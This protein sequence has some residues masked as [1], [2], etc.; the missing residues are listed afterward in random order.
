VNIDLDAILHT[1]LDESE[2]GLCRMEEA[3]VAL[4]TEPENDETLQT[5]FRVA[6]TLKGNASSLGFPL[7]AGFAHGVEDTLHALRDR[8]IPVTGSVIT[9]LLRAVDALRHMVPEAVAG[10][11]EMSP[12]HEALLKLLGETGTMAV[13]EKAKAAAALV[14]PERRQR[15]WGRRKDDI[16]AWKDRGRT[17]RVDIE[18]LDRI[19]NLT[20]EIAIA[21]GRL[22]QMLE[23]RV[24]RAGEEVLEAHLEADRLYLD[25][26]ELV[27]KARMVPVGPIF[28]QYVRT[29]RD[30]AAATGKSVRLLTEGGDVEVDTRVIEHLRDPLTHMIRN[31]VD[32]GIEPPQGRQARGKD[33]CGHVSLR[34]CHEAGSIVIQV[35]DDGSGFDRERIVEQA[36]SEGLVAEPEKLTDAEIYRLVFEP[37]FSTAEAV[38]DLSGRGV[39]MDIVRRNVEAL[40]GS[41]AIDSRQGEGTT[42]TIRLPLTLAIIEGFGVGVGDETYVI[43]LEAVLECLE[44][45]AEEKHRGNGRGVIYL[46]GQALPYLRLRDQFALPGPPPPRESIVVVH[47]GGGQAGIAVDVLYGASQTVIKPLGELFEGLPGIAGST[48]LGSGR[49]A[50]IL[51]VPSLL[52]EAVGRQSQSAGGA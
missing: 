44:L 45:P 49:V 24:G 36:R 33:P 27:M 23:E 3:L 32:H 52:R 28:R 13:E 21:R 25:L 47:H 12:G 37:G 20:G 6:H 30:M 10:N 46:R 31:A 35:A 34:A 26:Q 14:A 22:R 7:V 43:P 11:E 48:I 50:L 38:T 39:G 9:L 15:S 2:E 51:D 16:E 42:I 8:T 17:L 29:V 1:F 5:I 19:L 40:R 41:V 18:K 4:E